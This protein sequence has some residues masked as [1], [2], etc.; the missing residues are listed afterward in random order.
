MLSVELD[1]LPVSGFPLD[2][3]LLV[4]EASA[5]DYRK[6][7]DGAG[8]YVGVPLDLLPTIQALVL[9][10]DRALTLRLNGQ[11]DAGV[12]INAGGVVVLFDVTVNAGAGA[13]NA[14]V[15]NV[16]GATAFVQGVGGGT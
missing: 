15:N 10:A 1:G 7:V 14:K 4:D 6:A 9:R 16:S 2:R 8:T 12:L 3:R 11:S 13:A 5:I